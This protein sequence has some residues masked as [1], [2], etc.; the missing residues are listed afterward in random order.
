[1][2]RSSFVEVRPHENARQR[3]QYVLKHRDRD[4]MNCLGL[5]LGEKLVMF[6]VYDVSLHRGG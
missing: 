4:G 1:M 3:E 5:G 6:W 2:K